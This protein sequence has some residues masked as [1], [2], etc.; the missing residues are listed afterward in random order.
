M[1]DLKSLRM[2]W[3]SFH[4]DTSDILFFFFTRYKRHPVFAIPL[5]PCRSVLIHSYIPAFLLQNDPIDTSLFQLW[6]WWSEKSHRDRVRGQKSRYTP[7]P[8]FDVEVGSIRWISAGLGFIKLAMSPCK[9]N[10]LETGAGC[11]KKQKKIKKARKICKKTQKWYDNA[12]HKVWKRGFASFL[13]YMQ[14]S[15]SHFSFLNAVI[16]DSSTWDCN[17]VTPLPALKAADLRFR[18]QE[19]EARAPNSSLISISFLSL[20]WKKIDEYTI[21]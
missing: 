20:F 19:L 3:R 18:K 5:S 4:N 2:S 7:R 13:R 21:G 10:S 14:I 11:N 12:P 17:V 9:W 8:V 1:P 16:S 6:T 15:V